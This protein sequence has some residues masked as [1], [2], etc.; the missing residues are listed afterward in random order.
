MNYHA[1]QQQMANWCWAACIQMALSAKDIQISQEE[2][3]R[4]AFGDLRDAPRRIERDALEPQRLGPSHGGGR[5][6][7]VST[8]AEPGPP[9][10]E[11]LKLQLEAQTPVIVAIDNPGYSIGHAVVVT[12]VIYDLTPHGPEI[13]KVM[14]RDPWPD[15]AKDL[16]K[17]ELTA[18]EFHRIGG[19]YLIVP[20]D[21]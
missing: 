11:I 17:R 5:K 6:V 19:Y 16:G 13:I 8:A 12:A 15:R 14:I 1:A 3:V 20:T 9:S 2:V 4:R 7:C 21:L 10:F 18:E